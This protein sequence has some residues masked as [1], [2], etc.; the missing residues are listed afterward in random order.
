MATHW[1]SARSSH[2]EKKTEAKK[3][4]CLRTLKTLGKIQRLLYFPELRCP[5]TLLFQD[6]NQFR[7]NVKPRISSFTRG[8]FN[9]GGTILV[10]NDHYWEGSPVVP[11]LL[12]HQPTIHQSAK[13]SSPSSR[14]HAVT[15]TVWN[16]QSLSRK[17][18]RSRISGWTGIIPPPAL[19]DMLVLDNRDVSIWGDQQFNEIK[20]V[21]NPFNKPIN[22]LIGWP[23][24]KHIIYHCLPTICNGHWL[25]DEMLLKLLQGISHDKMGSP[26]AIWFSWLK[27]IVKR[28]MMLSWTRI[29]TKSVPN[30]I[31]SHSQFYYQIINQ[32]IRYLVFPWTILK[33]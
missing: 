19:W 2:P 21:L 26:I 11:D 7:P 31:R 9:W 24:D 18:H 13:T 8:L 4:P 22:P 14:L 28:G 10:A 15:G 3:R 17:R 12:S 30:P 27:D 6:I 1:R 16:L 33:L 20:L 23:I 32:I 29:W 25:L 5:R